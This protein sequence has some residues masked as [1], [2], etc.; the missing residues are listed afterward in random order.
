[1]CCSDSG[2]EGT[3]LGCR[4]PLLVVIAV[5]G[6]IPLLN[7]ACHYV[8]PQCLFLGSGPDATRQHGSLALFLRL[9]H[10]FVSLFLYDD[11]GVVYRDVAG[12]VTVCRR[13]PEGRHAA[14]A[15]LWTRPILE[16]SA[17]LCGPG[18]AYVPSGDEV[19]PS[20][21]GKST[22]LDAERRLD[23]ILRGP[24]GAA[25]VGVM[26][27]PVG[28]LSYIELTYYVL[29]DESTLRWDL[30]SELPKELDEAVTA[31]L[32]LLCETSRKLARGLRR[33]HPEL[34]SRAGCQN[35]GPWREASGAPLPGDTPD[36]GRKV[37]APG[38]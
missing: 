36:G 11:G 38:E 2:A 9:Q 6:M 27:R 17:P 28:R 31:M 32:G 26:Q 13:M 3:R 5:A 34:A 35:V 33:S 8:D 18:Y 22:V 20:A 16:R 37:R 23:R 25:W 4:R 29:E 24:C 1:M 15:D 7:T 30:E 21:S 10:R 12:S 19:R 14:L